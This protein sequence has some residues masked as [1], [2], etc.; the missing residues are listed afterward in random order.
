ME[1]GGDYVLINGDV[2]DIKSVEEATENFVSAVGAVTFPGKYENRPG[3]KISDLVHQVVLQPDARLDFAVLLRYQP[4]G[5]YRYQR[6]NLQQ[7]LDNP[8]VPENLVLGDHDVLEVITLRLYADEGQFTV[9]GAV[10]KPDTFKF[11]PRGNLKLEDALLL[12]GGLELDAAP[13]GYIIRHDPKEPKIVQYLPID[14]QKAM[15]DPSSNQNVTVLTG[16]VIRVFNKYDRRDDIYVSISGAVRNPG[17]YSFGPEMRLSDLV[18]LAGGFTFDAD[19]HRI[20]IARLDFGDGQKLKVTQ[21]TTELSSRLE[22]VD[23]SMPLVPYDQVYVRS[24]P[25]FELQQIVRVEG[26]IKYPGNYALLKD[27]ERIYDL[28]ERAGGLTGEAFPEGAKLYRTT[29]STGL[30]VI[31]LKNIL[32]NK[33]V[34]SNI[35]LIAGDVINIPKSRDLVSIEGHV[36]L[37]EVYSPGFLSGENSISVAFRGEK[38]A[39]YYVDHFAAGVSEDGS[40]SEILVQYADG[41]VEKTRKLLFFNSYPKIKRGSHIVVGQKIVKPEAP[42]PETKTDWASVLKDTMAQA[43]AVLTILILVDQLSK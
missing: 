18:S 15:D 30:V 17:Q 22:S 33:N 36:N 10:K 41:R 26:E 2:V 29:D 37:D 40:P 28:I 12:A 6:I 25:E 13:Q 7:I 24:I 20:D 34:P 35:V 23:G 4:D 16:D 1:H 19:P 11:D 9:E 14:F 38:S 3:M 32:Q 43:T 21:S 42:K 31:D 5:T 27:K 8:G 39:K